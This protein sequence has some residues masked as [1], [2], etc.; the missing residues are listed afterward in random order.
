M[1]VTPAIDDVITT[2]AWPVAFSSRGRQAR[3]IWN[4]PT[5]F[6]A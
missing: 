5:V 1:P 2:L 6:T 3:I 4:G